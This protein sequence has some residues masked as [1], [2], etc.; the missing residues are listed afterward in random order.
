MEDVIDK[1]EEIV[2]GLDGNDV[3]IKIVVDLVKFLEIFN[4][5]D[6]EIKK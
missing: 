6:F 5:V 4:F 3:F 1:I 2:M